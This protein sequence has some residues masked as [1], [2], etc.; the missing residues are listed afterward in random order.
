VILRAATIGRGLTLVCAAELVVAC[1]SG[2]GLP[3]PNLAATWKSY[4]E[5]PA[6]RALAIAGDPRRT[7]WVAGASGGH[8]SRREAEAEALMECRL[9]RAA[10]R[11]QDVCLLYAVGDEIVWAGP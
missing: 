11:M 6:E 2:G 3:H 5:L 8:G 7:H 4:R 10:R 1:A 9:R